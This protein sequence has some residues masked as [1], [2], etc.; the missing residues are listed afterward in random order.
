[1]K[2]PTLEGVTTPQHPRVARRLDFG[3]EFESRGV[4]LQEPPKVTGAF[5][6]LVP[7]V[8]A[9]GIDLG[10][11]RLPEVSVPLATL[12]GW[13]LRS[14]QRGAQDQI[15]E[16][17][18]S[19]FPLAKTKEQRAAA[20]DPRFIHRGTLRQPRGLPEARQRGGRRTD[21]PAIRPAAGP[22]F[23]GGA[24]RAALGCPCQVRTF[25]VFTQP[26]DWPE[27]FHFPEILSAEERNRCARFVRAVDRARYVQAH[28]FLRETLSRFAAVAPSEWQFTRGEFGRPAIAG[29]IAGMGLEFN[30]SHTSDWTAVVVT[31]GVP[32]GIDIELIRP[33]PEMLDIAHRNFAPEELRAL[34]QLDE[35][36]RPRRFFEL[37]TEKEAWLKASG[38]GLSLP[39][40][41]I[42]SEV[43]GLTIERFH[44]T[45]NHA[46]ALA[47]Y[48]DNQN[49]LGD[50]SD[51][52]GHAFRPAAGLP[53]GV[54]LERRSSLYCA[55][56][57]KS[58]ARNGSPHHDRSWRY[59]AIPGSPNP[60]RG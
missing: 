24:G 56:L 44:P 9:D 46:M 22:R 31:R 60:D 21:A 3:P 39:M 38:G 18:G 52:V 27:D 25:E 1:M 54:P 7:Q 43:P 2:F 17:Y 4:I 16:F 12:T 53:P 42:V 37:W 32:Y 40:N 5:P 28:E 14:A 13:N 51:L 34:E 8:D 15:A 19:T 29:P 23:R 45:K 36:T 59:G 49:P 11:V 20:H 50:E 26:L 47:H 58:F 35:N 33:I 30:L 55:K 57:S 6:V 48:S 10:G 41:R